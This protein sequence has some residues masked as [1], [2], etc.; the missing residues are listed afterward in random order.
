MNWIFIPGGPGLGSEIIAPLTQLLKTTLP[1]NIW[2]FDLPN[3]GSNLLQDHLACNW[4]GAILQAVDSLQNVIIV[5]HSTLAM[6]V[7]TL[8]DLESILHGLV[9]MG[10]APDA[11]WQKIF[12]SYH[13]NHI[14][15]FIILAEKE[16]LANPNNETL[17]KLLLAEAKNCFV[18]DV[19]LL[20]GRKLLNNAPINH[21]ADMLYRDV[22][23][24]EQYVATWIPQNLN[25]LIISGEKDYI[26]PLELFLKNPFYQRDNITAKSIS[27]A[28]HYPWMENPQ[29]VVATFES[30]IKI[31]RIISQLPHPKLFR[32][33][34]YYYLS[35]P[36]KII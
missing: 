1:G 13:L 5:A 23:N 27:G 29:E 26:T 28:G 9:L 10:T 25:T 2:H 32:F 17:R 20:A 18:T 22:F 21:M 11:T 30:F 36:G 7:Q 3:D 24:S 35:T 12:A 16:Y 14:D 31:A 34:T 4:S 6:F 19:S 33:P 15:E 8:P